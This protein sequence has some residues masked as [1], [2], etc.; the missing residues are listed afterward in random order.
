MLIVIA[1]AVLLILNGVASLVLVRVG[2]IERGQRIAQALLV[3]LLPV[4]GAA[5]VL[6]VN[7]E[8]TRATVPVRGASPDD[9]TSMSQMQLGEN[10]GSVSSGADCGGHSCS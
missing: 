8:L 7:R 6:A 3:W 4:V 10:G 1:A 2:G 9:V 5:V